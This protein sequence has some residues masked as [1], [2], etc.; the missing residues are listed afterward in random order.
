[1]GGA[2][3]GME[4]SQ[5]RYAEEEEG[6]QDVDDDSLFRF[7][8][9]DVEELENFDTENDQLSEEDEDQNEDDEDY[10]SDGQTPVGDPNCEDQQADD[11]DTDAYDEEE[12]DMYELELEFMRSRKRKRKSGEDRISS[13][14][15]DR[16][17]EED[18][19]KGKRTKRTGRRRRKSSGLPKHLEGLMGEA[20]TL[21]M[22]REFDDALKILRRIAKDAPKA[23]PPYHT[24]GLIHEEL[25]DPRRALDYYMIAALLERSDAALWRKNALHSMS[26]GNI[27]QA[28]FCFSMA[29]KYSK[30]KD[31]ASLERLAELREER[32]DIRRAAETFERLLRRTPERHDVVFRIADLYESIALPEKSVNVLYTA[33]EQV[34]AE[35]DLEKV[36]PRMMNKMVEGLFVLR[37][38]VDAGALLT[39]YCLLTAG[40]DEKFPV[41]LRV[42]QAIC[43]IRL[44]SKKPREELE[45]ALGWLGSQYS[46]Y[47]S[48]FWDLGEALLDEKHF[49][50]SISVFN[51]LEAFE[52]SN[53][54]LLLRRGT[55]Y[56]E[57][58]QLNK[59]KLDLEKAVELSHGM[60][61]ASMQLVELYPKIGEETK[62]TGILKKIEG[63]MREK[64]HAVAAAEE[65]VLRILGFAERYELEDPHRYVETLLPLMD[66]ACNLPRR[67]AADASK[68]NSGELL[69]GIE[70]ESEEPSE[71]GGEGWLF[72]FS[73]GRR[74]AKKSGKEKYGFS[75]RDVGIAVRKVLT[76]EQ[77]LDLLE[78]FWRAM[79]DIDREEQAALIVSRLVYLKEVA[80][81]N[82]IERLRLLGVA[83]SIRGRQLMH[84]YD[85]LRGL[86]TEQPD[87][88]TYWYVLSALVGLHKNG[89][90]R[91][92]AKA[93]FKFTNRLCAKNPG[94]LPCLLSV[95][96]G[97][98]ESGSY[99]WGGFFLEAIINVRD[100]S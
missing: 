27:D 65:T 52:Q 56:K 53:T 26:L 31:L 39:R 72:Q 41:D 30:G 73:T 66:A 34:L 11:E 64:A 8:E 22:R 29:V 19:R 9:Q 89:K 76:D 77:Y 35:G 70:R 55:A 88:A 96:N 32:R 79:C 3:R 100:E 92:L 23:I 1:M 21:Y 83:A 48:L 5:N 82:L 37:K 69:H 49:E 58:G 10:G 50:L 99:R 15:V 94:V 68:T 67:N 75:M 78:K 16:I 44:G 84:A 90:R 61:E 7:D 81:V 14:T 24:L 45:Q 57:L 93:T 86:C 33:M 36:D 18:Q 40:H 87:Q 13:T 71:G 20:N 38:Y 47:K 17:L 62:I 98:Y 51:E 12:E 74:R 2:K 28:I 46:K 80:D 42:R 95:G 63:S 85:E 25:N 59:A 91:N 97:F 4:E 6:G 60:V 43:N 54:G